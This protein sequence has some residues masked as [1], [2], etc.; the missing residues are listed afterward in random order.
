MSE[1]MK[2]A[3]IQLVLRYLE[4][5]SDR[6]HPVSAA[7][8]ISM[9]EK[10]GVSAERKAIYSD[11][12]ALCSVGVPIETGGKKHGYFIAERQFGIP[13]VCLL[14]DAVQSA[15]FI[16]A[17]KSR[18]LISRLEKQVSVHEAETLRGRVCID[19]R[20][21]STNDSLYS[22]IEALNT[23]ISTRKKVELCYFKNVL[24]KN[25][26]ETAERSF[27]VSPYS[28]LWDNDHYYLICNN[29]KY[30]NLM[31]L[32]IDRCRSARVTAEPWRHFS[33]VSEYSQ[34]FDTADYARK[35]FNMFG[36]EVCRIDLECDKDLLDQVLDRF[37][38]E[39][40]I[41]SLPDD[42]AFRFT[43]DALISEGLVGWIMQFGGRVRCLSPKTLRDDL[44][45]KAEDL[46]RSST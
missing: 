32:R 36:G 42:T 24:G 1:A 41:R 14:I 15:E 40:M 3:R 39:I 35:V 16:P 33:E 9:L 17:K 44:K 6:L 22:I 27:K 21:K 34:R 26:L 37:G 25:G 28:L 18:D 2:K 8:L 11:I 46:L 31:H 4:E 5:Q 30:D 43:A 12:A 13:E 45:K 23:A 19:N 38:R 20:P 10:N 29:E 7:E